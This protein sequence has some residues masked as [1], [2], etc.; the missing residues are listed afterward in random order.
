MRLSLQLTRTLGE[1]EEE[2]EKFKRKLGSSKIY[3]FEHLEIS[4]ISGS[5]IE[6]LKN[7]D[8]ARHRDEPLNIHALQSTQCT[9]IFTKFVWNI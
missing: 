4:E 5:V 2:L 1:L 6:S 9:C 3:E 7:F 8:S